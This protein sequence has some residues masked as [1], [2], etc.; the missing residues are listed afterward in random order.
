MRC[1]P[2]PCCLTLTPASPLPRRFTEFLTENPAQGVALHVV[3]SAAITVSGIPFALVDLGAA[4]VYRESPAKVLAMLLLAKTVG[5]AVCFLIARGLLSEQRKAS[6]LEHATI[7][8]VNKVLKTSPLYYG[9]LC[10]LATMPA[11]VK[12]YGLALLD[13]EFPTY[14]GCCLLGSTVGVPLQGMLGMQLGAVYLGVATEGDAADA[15]PGAE[16]TAGIVVGVV[17]TL[18]VVKLLVS[19]ALSGD[20]DDDDEKTPPSAAGATEVRL[21][22]G[23]MVCGGCQA[24]VKKALEAVAGVS[25]VTVELDPGSAVVTGTATVEALIAAVEAKGKTASLAKATEENV[26]AAAG[27]GRPKAE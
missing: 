22:V 5:S 18:L 15:L 3:L 4:W 16:A 1:R 9:T 12:N 13:I 10:R 23:G 17:C 20:G 14:M 2:R 21:S 24:N 7:K 27:A 25:S 8:R 19:A 11:A 26:A 6:L